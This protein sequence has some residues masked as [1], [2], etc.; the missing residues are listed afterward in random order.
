MTAHAT[1]CTC[2]PMRRLVHAAAEGA[3]I[4]PCP[5]HRPDQATPSTATPLNGDHLLDAL[6]A[7]VNR[8]TAPEK[9]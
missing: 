5:R 7:A 9:E 2:P 6:V 3:A 1:S 4:P 8:R